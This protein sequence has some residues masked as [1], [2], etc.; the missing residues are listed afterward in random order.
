MAAATPVLAA[1]RG[2][3]SHW[4]FTASIFF[5]LAPT[6]PAIAALS[7]CHLAEAARKT[8]PQCYKLLYT[9]QG[10]VTPDRIPL[11][12]YMKKLPGVLMAVLLFA[13]SLS[14]A[15]GKFILTL[16][17][18]GLNLPANS[19]TGQSSQGKVFP[20]IKMAFIVSRNL[21]LWAGYGFFPLRDSWEDWSSKGA[22]AKDVSVERTLTK[23]IL[24]FGFGY[25]IGFL[26]QGQ[27]ALRPEIGVCWIVNSIGKDFSAIGSGGLIRSETARQSAIGLRGDL[28]FAYGLYRNI[29]AELSGG[30]MYAADKVGSVRNNLGGFHLAAGLGINF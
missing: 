7:G 11:E 27:L 4:G 5:N 22:F 24:S 19:F 18:D 29:F 15:D 6:T 10:K 13:S 30:Y 23:R 16:Y 25:L 9:T 2:C 1:F 26:E 8:L 28:S 21:Y 17:G 14:A 12:E 3:H 20:E